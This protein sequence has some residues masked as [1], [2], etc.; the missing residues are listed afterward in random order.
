MQNSGDMLRQIAENAF[1]IK[2]R[3]QKIA[4]YT[5]LPGGS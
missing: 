5:Y 1:Q 3:I 4:E 2:N